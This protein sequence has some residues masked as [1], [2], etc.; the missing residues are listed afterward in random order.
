MCLRLACS[1]L[2][3][4]DASCSDI[5]CLIPVRLS[6]RRVWVMGSVSVVPV[7]TGAN[8]AS[9]HTPHHVQISRLHKTE[10]QTSVL[11]AGQDIVSQGSLRVRGA[12]STTA[13]FQ[14]AVFVASWA[15]S[16]AP[17]PH[18]VTTA[19]ADCEA[20]YAHVLSYGNP[21]ELLPNDS[22]AGTWYL[23]NTRRMLQTGP[24]VQ[25]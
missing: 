20:K 22:H 17:W 8:P 23:Q 9:I 1:P 12:P 5:S 6:G 2:R 24:H 19:P 4:K 25:V 15:C 16:A 7:V 21:R 10:F 13:M 11:V 18:N 3:N 14:S